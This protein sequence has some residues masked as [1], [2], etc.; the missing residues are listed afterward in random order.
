MSAPRNVIWISSYPKSGNTWV[1]FIVSGVLKDGP[2]ET[3]GEIEA[4]TPDIHKHSLD[5]LPMARGQLFL[6]THWACAPAMPLYGVTKGAIY[7]VRHP[8]DVLASNLA[9]LGYSKNR[10]KNLVEE[11]I[12]K[13]GLI[14]WT[15]FRMGTW[16][17]SIESWCFREHPFPVLVLRYEDLSAAPVDRIQ[18]IARFIDHPVSADIAGKIA[19]GTRFSSMRTMEMRERNQG[20]SRENSFFVTEATD[21][22]K[23]KRSFMRTGK[24]QQYRKLLSPNQQAR[25]ERRFDGYLKKLGY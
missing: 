24:V 7:I 13:G 23:G 4:L 19:H 2:L 17:E 25:F 11:F 16:V 22:L 12:E 20:L 10:Q 1:R 14:H 6:K 21:D 15:R 8:G 5:Q 18:E 3:S 9:Y